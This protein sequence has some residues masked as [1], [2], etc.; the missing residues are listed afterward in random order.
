MDK[1]ELFLTVNPVFAT[2]KG[3]L[4]LLENTGLK[5]AEK[6]GSLI[7]T[8]VAGSA[9]NTSP[10][11]IRSYMVSNEARYHIG[12]IMAK[13]SDCDVI[14]DLPCGY[15]PR[16]LVITE[17]GKQ[18]YGFDLPAVI[19]ELEPAIRSIASEEQNERMHFC[20]VDATNYE[21]L[22]IALEGVNGKICILT[23]GLL[24]YFNEPELNSVC[25]NIRRLLSEY[26]G[27]WI[28]A[29]KYAW[30]L[31]AETFNALTDSDGEIVK[32]MMKKGG[33]KV[34]DIPV[35]HTVIQDGPAEDAMKYFE[36]YGFEIKTVSYAEKLPDLSSLRDCPE[37]MGRLRKA[38]NNIML[39][40]MSVRPSENRTREKSVKAES[41]SADFSC[42]EGRLLCRL[43][44]RLD[45]ISAPDFL[46]GFREYQTEDLKEITLDLKDTVYISSAGLRVLLIMYKA[47]P[48]PENFRLENISADVMSILEMTGFAAILGLQQ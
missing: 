45:T 30:Q 6:L 37:E 10:E 18:F 21:S 16:G 38:Y 15:V 40:I 17:T 46:V 2:A 39:W 35:N 14:V 5:E 33:T 43:S 1:K 24:G 4:G 47:L 22:K 23:D 12:N 19:E 7:D 13:E 25:E 31:G 42:E 27:V 26:G 44:G 11:I 34:A 28:T 3:C 41:F 8:T 20:A 9:G 32:E 48:S 29:D 36:K